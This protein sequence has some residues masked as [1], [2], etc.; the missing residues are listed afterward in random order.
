MMQGNNR[1]TLSTSPGNRTSAEIAGSSGGRVRDGGGGG[2]LNVGTMPAN[3]R[4][5]DDA[6]LHTE[7]APVPQ[8]QPPLLP[9]RYG[10][11]TATARAGIADESLPLGDQHFSNQQKQQTLSRTRRNTDTSS[12][13]SSP[14]GQQPAAAAAT[15]S[16]AAAAGQNTRDA[17]CEQIV[18][19]F[20]SK[21][22]QVIA[23][24]RGGRTSVRFL[25]SSSRF[26]HGLELEGASAISPRLM[27]AGGSNSAMDLSSAS[28]SVV[29]V[30]SGG[31]RI[32]KWFNLDFEDIGEVKEEAKFWRHAAVNSHLPLHAPQPPSMLI[33]V[34]L[35]ISGI[36][37]GDELQVTD[38]FGRP[39]NV[40]LEMGVSDNSSSVGLPPAPMPFAGSHG[41]SSA[42][43]RASAIVLEVW[44]LDLNIAQV[45]AP[46]PDLPRVYKQ[47]IVF[48]RSLYSFA[49]LLPCVALG[50]QLQQQQQTNSDNLGIFCTFRHSITPRNGFI[51]LDASLTGTEKFLESHAFEPVPTPMGTFV[52][53]VQYRRECLFSRMPHAN[54]P[55]QGSFNAIGAI[56]DSYFTP[57]L[58]SRSGS[59][60]SLSRQMQ[61]HN[62][63]GLHPQRQHH[64][65]AQ[66]S[67]AQQ[68]LPEAQGFGTSLG[69][70]RGLT[71]LS[72][73]PFRARPV[74]LGDSS[75]LS[76]YIRGDGTSSRRT[77][78]RTSAEL[79]NSSRLHSTG[80]DAGG[81][82]S[83]SKTSLRR[84]SLGARSHGAPVT[85]GASTSASASAIPGAV[86]GG[87]ASEPVTGT[88][89]YD[90]GGN[91][92]SN[93]ASSRPRSFDQKGA[94]IGSGTVDSG[95]M[96]HRSAMLRRFGDSLS[97]GEHQ[98]QHR[99]H[100][101]PGYVSGSKSPT[102]SIGSVTRRSSLGFAPFKSPS[103]SESPKQR[104]GGIFSGINDMAE[105]G[106]GS[107]SRGRGYTL[108]YESGMS[109]SPSQQHSVGGMHQLMTKLSDSPS[110]LGSNWSSGHSRGLSSSFGN[111]RVSMSRRRPSILAA[112][113]SAGD[114]SRGESQGLM[115]RH[116]IVEDQAWADDQDDQ[117][118]DAFIRMV[119]TKQPLRVY[120]RK[121]GP[122]SRQ[123]SASGTTSL[124]RRPTATGLPLSAGMAGL[125]GSPRGRHDVFGSPPLV[126]GTS[127][128][129][130]TQG[131]PGNN[132]SLGMYRG[133]V[134]DFNG[135]SQDMQNSV[136]TASAPA[137][138]MA[139]VGLASGHFGSPFRRQQAMPNPLR[140][141]D[142]AGSASSRP[143]SLSSVVTLPMAGATAG[144][145]SRQD[146]AN[147]PSLS[148]LADQKQNVSVHDGRSIDML[149]QAFNNMAIGSKRETD[150]HY[151]RLLAPRVQT[152]SSSGITRSHIRSAAPGLDSES[153]R[154]L[155]QPVSIPHSPANAP[156]FGVRQP[157]QSQ[158]RNNLL[159]RD[160]GDLDFG[161]DD[162]SNVAAFI[163]V[164]GS[165]V[166]NARG[167]SQPAL[168]ASELGP[169][170][171]PRVYTP[172][173]PLARN[174]LAQQEN[175]RFSPDMGGVLSSRSDFVSSN[176]QLGTLLSMADEAAGSSR[177]TP[178]ST[179]S[180]PSQKYPA[181]VVDLVQAT[182][183]EGRHG[184]GQRTPRFRG[185]QHQRPSDPLRSNFPP[186]SF[187]VPRGRVEQIAVD[188]SA[189]SS[190][191]SVGGMRD[192][193]AASLVADGT[194][195][196]ENDD[197]DDLM[198]QMETSSTR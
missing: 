34:C 171:E 180:T 155:P 78:S 151:D 102:G 5:S 139:G 87:A 123:S 8:Q 89:L 84:I 146:S 168:H 27:A 11:T 144:N 40:D 61:Q 82:L 152:A 198:F 95:S 73:N 192:T 138:E 17:R 64:Q 167:R 148:A 143:A 164:G 163:G 112:P 184:S 22:A 41:D 74:S 23:H 2:S 172:Q 7:L 71:I 16:A 15:G 25:D 59:N 149:H 72:V 187:I 44:R 9:P 122:S 103:L 193:S 33:E 190:V 28:S 145:R 129:V 110:S 62:P 31:R 118:I 18:Q 43:R 24:L 170:M 189:A 133:L 113:L 128:R 52:M 183:N 127:A 175:M 57:T 174:R 131:Y 76:G 132:E 21:T 3:I 124:F 104:L 47:A 6:R 111:R 67:L 20:Y 147:S 115:R 60:F 94:S 105:M 30:G 186:L 169:A 92:G 85:G 65:R 45:P 80:T 154:P 75:S 96:L 69:S 158:Q 126:A 173:P 156:R 32:N 49:S 142:R 79:G 90:I 14:L 119:D 55:L 37:V 29:D 58:S 86:T 19:N 99:P 42:Q 66:P 39:W 121:D 179:P 1:S 88:L 100:D 109:Q 36:A 120:S 91:G 108:G 107:G 53:S 136:I 194:D 13:S 135:L 137:D 130:P 157:H 50:Q 141:N 101:V 185:Q 177:S 181:T 56:D 165:G 46:V 114:H 63:H 116:T 197:E 51:D 26:D 188:L 38:I 81:K 83:S 54:A 125:A 4:R 48:F 68:G 93:I 12:L 176:H 70:D 10:T 117:D 161:I 140:S 106:S 159:R 195:E 160:D 150:H 182:S 98:H 166:S 153:E 178:H 191:A 35:D 97:P 196:D 77:A 134:N 162:D